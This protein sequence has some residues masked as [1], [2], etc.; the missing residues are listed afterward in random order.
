MALGRIYVIPFT[1]IGV[2]GTVDLW[3][4]AATANMAFELHDIDLGAET[5]TTAEELRI[6]F[7]VLTATVTNGSGGAAITPVAMPV[8]GAAATVTASGCTTGRATTNGTSSTIRATS[9]QLTNGYIYQWPP[10]DRPLLRPSQNLII[11]LEVA[12]A[13]P[14]ILNGVITI[15]EIF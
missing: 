11:G 7:K 3:N 13:A 12:P 6:S 15:A 14:H 5:A 1:N 4:V 2:S 9:W 10:E 8:G